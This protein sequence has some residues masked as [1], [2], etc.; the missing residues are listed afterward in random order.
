[1]NHPIMNANQYS[2]PVSTQ[3]RITELAMAALRAMGV[4]PD[5]SNEGEAPCLTVEM[6]EKSEE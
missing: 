3:E 6:H 4:D 5:G 2:N 1:M